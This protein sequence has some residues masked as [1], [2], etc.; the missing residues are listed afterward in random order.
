MNIS[1]PL[2]W[3]AMAEWREQEAALESQLE[4]MQDRVE[5]AVR[6]ARLRGTESAYKDGGI[7]PSWASGDGVVVSITKTM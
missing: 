1:S 5:E 3:A 4:A 2:F 7:S 6:E